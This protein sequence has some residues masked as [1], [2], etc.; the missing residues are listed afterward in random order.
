MFP[1]SAVGCQ[2]ITANQMNT[3]T[4]D[5]GIKRPGTDELRRKFLSCFEAR[6]SNAIAMQQ[7]VKSLVAQ[8][9]P[10]TTLVGW[11]VLAGCSRGYASKLLCR[12]FTALNLRDRRAGAGR[13]PSPETGELLDLAYARFGE[14]SVKLLRAAWRAG[15][16]QMAAG[17]GHF[18]PSHGTAQNLAVASPSP[19]LGAN[20]GPVINHAMKQVPDVQAG[21][22]LGANYGPVI[23]WH[24]KGAAGVNVVSISPMDSFSEENFAHRKA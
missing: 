9:I 8:G 23:I 1:S 14:R 18:S 3:L 5:G 21:C 17:T 22:H 7:I 4:L 10:R 16:A 2:K 24:G 6:T 12:I 19:Q 13:K 15:K 11:L 20:Y